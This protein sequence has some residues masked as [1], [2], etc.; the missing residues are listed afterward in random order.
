MHVSFNIAPKRYYELI[1]KIVKVSGI[2]DIFDKS[3]VQRL[4]V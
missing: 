3:D 1:N 4:I 2:F